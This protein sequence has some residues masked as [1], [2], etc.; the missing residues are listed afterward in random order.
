MQ[1]NKPFI[2]WVSFNIATPR[3]WRRILMHTVEWEPGL[4]D[5]LPDFSS[6]DRQVI[7]KTIRLVKQIWMRIV[8]I[9]CWAGV[10]RRVLQW[11]GFTLLQ[12]VAGAAQSQTWLCLVI[13]SLTFSV[14]VLNEIYS[15]KKGMWKKIVC[16]QDKP[17]FWGA[18]GA[19][20]SLPH[21][22]N[23]CQRS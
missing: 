19:A 2:W 23:R 5:F 12:A 22:V 18:G 20:F 7:L 3:F 6:L 4:R 8:T 11:A 17:C 16:L 14:Q 10:E 1:G 9:D 21:H 15:K 13:G